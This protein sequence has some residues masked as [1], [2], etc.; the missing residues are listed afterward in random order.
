MPIPELAFVLTLLLPQAGSPSPN[1]T[2]PD[3]SVLLQ[4]NRPMEARAVFEEALGRD[5]SNAAAQ[6][7]EMA[8]SERLALQARAEGHMDDALQT[9]LRA[10][11]YAPQNAHLLYDLGILEDE[12]RLFQDADR[13]LSESD[14]IQPGDARTLYG[15]ARVKLDLEQLAAAEEKMKAYLALRPNDATAHFG[16]GRIYQIGLQAEKAKVEFL[17][18]AELQPVQTEAYFELGDLALKDGEFDEAITEFAKTLERDP[19]HGGSLEGTGE[20]YF[21]KKDFKK[22][23]DFL[24][25]AISAAP[26]YSPS[27]YYLGLTLTKLGRKSEAEKELALAAKLANGDNAATKQHPQ[28]QE[29]PAAT[30]QL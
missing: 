10:R 27:H 23:E 17:K 15:M 24:E 30:P 29:T 18:S 11:N 5:P 3:G 21:K 6:A 4:A 16:L 19:K 26:D 14:R 28:L 12:M 1:V 8:A 22:A 9:L 2:A 20:A 7:G 13:S 25:R